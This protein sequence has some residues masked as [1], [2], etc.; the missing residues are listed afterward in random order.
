[1]AK[2]L[3][4]PRRKVLIVDDEPEN[5]DILLQA[6]SRTYVILAARTGEKALQL[7]KTK[8]PDIILLDIMM[9]NIDGYEVCRRLK[10]DPETCD[11]PVIFL[12]ALQHEGDEMMG[13]SLGAV[14]YIHKPICLPLLQARL[15]THLELAEAKRT[16][17]RQVLELEDAARLRDDVDNITRHDLKGPLSP[18]LTYP[19][20]LMRN[21]ALNER[22]RKMLKGMQKAGE[23]VLRMINQSLDL[24]KIES[25]KYQYHAEALNLSEML[26]KV[27]ADLEGLATNLGVSFAIDLPKLWVMGDDGLCQTML[28]NLLKN[29]IEAIPDQGVVQIQGQQNGDWAKLS[30]T[31]PSTVPEAIRECFFDK[32]VTAGKK[33]GTGLGT[34]SAQLMAKTMGGELLMDCDEA[35][36]GTRIT[37]RL[38]TMPRDSQHSSPSPS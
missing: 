8:H 25:G 30:I 10:A 3:D 32:Y 7:A 20:L 9:P 36:Y 26:T 37:I 11:I 22:E 19:K 34:Y 13:F 28:S 12:T 5:L 33:G 1:M 15:A 14:D 6:L 21:P 24:Y 38:L 29:A 17:A 4:V 27:I 18:I 23:D 31:N 2:Q 35:Y 16:L